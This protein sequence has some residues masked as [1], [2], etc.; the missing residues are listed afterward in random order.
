MSQ[1]ALDEKI[2]EEF[3]ANVSAKNI[4]SGDSIKE[5]KKFINKQNVSEEDWG[6]LADK[7]CF[8]SSKKEAQNGK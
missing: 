7:A 4:L 5:L 6:F 3:M 1:Q 8:P 2:F